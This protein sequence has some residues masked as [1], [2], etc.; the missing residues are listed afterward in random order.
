MKDEKNKDKVENKENAIE[1]KNLWKQFTISH[2]K[3]S[4][5]KEGVINFLRRSRVNNENIWAL[6]KVSFDVKKGECIGI[7]GVNGSGKTTLLRVLSNILPPTKGEVKIKGKIAPLLNLG[8]GFEP[9]LT[10]KEN[11]YLYGSLMGLSKEDLD[12]KYQDIVNFSELDG[13]MDTKLKNFSSGM[14]LRLGFSTAVNV[15]ADI[16]LVDEFLAVGDIGFQKKCL[17]KIEE[18][19]K[20]G[21]TIVLVT[22]NVELAEKICDRTIFL[23]KGSIKNI[24][25]T[26]KIVN[27]YK[28]YALKHGL[29]KTAHEKNVINKQVEL[30]ELHLEDHG[31]INETFLSGDRFV[32]N[33][34]F[35]SSKVIKNPVISMW[36]KKTAN[37]K[38]S[39]MLDNKKPI[40]EDGK[41]CEKLTGVANIKAI[42]GHMP[43]KQGIYEL[44]VSMSDIK[45]NSIVYPN[46]MKKISFRITGESIMGK[47]YVKSRTRR[48][49]QIPIALIVESK[50]NMAD[51]KKTI[52]HAWDEEIQ[53]QDQIPDYKAK[54]IKLKRMGPLDRELW[55]KKER[56]RNG[57]GRVDIL[58]VKMFDENDVEKTTFENNEDVKIK[59]FYDAKELIKNPIFS[60]GIFGQN[61]GDYLELNTKNKEVAKSIS[62]KGIVSLKINSGELKKDVFKV[63]AGVFAY[64]PRHPKELYMRDYPFDYFYR[65]FEFEVV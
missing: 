35:K 44:I 28:D 53:N 4:S 16:L 33:M 63:S 1:V 52:P 6:K 56:T 5:L 32:V 7:I 22:H 23:D 24:G 54:T 40:Y 49:R 48:M 25:G 55:Y 3:I 15:D 27:I 41:V 62:G 42:F 14:E 9:E 45:N 36:V 29:R 37:G 34:K 17:E 13:Y 2:E 11:L 60:I 64:H 50:K 38:L 21:K 58:N 51:D 46:T 26:G 8:I 20:E 18:F 31:G 57:H 59:I 65:C 12:K 47:N 39:Q 61:S 43:L 10:A 30:S 19:K